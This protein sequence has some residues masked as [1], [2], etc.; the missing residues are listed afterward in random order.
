MTSSDVTPWLPD[1]CCRCGEKI[2]RSKQGFGC[3]YA[4]SGSVERPVPTV[5]HLPACPGDTLAVS[6]QRSDC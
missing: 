3:S 1:L 2:L 4:G 5:W 6:R